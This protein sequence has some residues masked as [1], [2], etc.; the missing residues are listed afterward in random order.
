MDSHIYAG[1]SIPPY[2]DSMIAKL[3][4]SAKDRKSAIARMARALDEFMI[5]GVQTT[6]PFGQLILQD[7]DFRRGE[8]STHF[9]ERLMLQQKHNHPT[10][11]K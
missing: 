2:Y 8:Y 11:P 4:V 9:V 3:I 1:Y 5:Q 10:P 6:I 7:P